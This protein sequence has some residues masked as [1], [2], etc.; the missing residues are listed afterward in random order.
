M[1]TSMSADS[2]ARIAPAAWRR[3]PTLVRAVIAG[4]AV[5]V[6]ATGPC[7]GLA[8]ANLRHALWLPWSG[9]VVALYLWAY[10]RYLQGRGWPAA[11]AEARRRGLR[12]RRLPWRVW[13]WSLAAG[14]L[15]WG[16]VLAARIAVDLWLD[17]PSSPASSLD[18]YPPLAVVQYVLTASALAGIAEEA[19]FRGYMQGPL[20]RRYGPLAAVLVVGVA[21]W[22]A[23]GGAYREDPW[24]FVGRLWFY[25]AGS[26]V[27]GTLAHLTGS[28]LPGIVLHAAAD[29]LGFGLLWLWS[30]GGGVSA[31]AAGAAGLACLGPAVLAYRRLA[32]ETA[33]GRARPPAGPDEAVGLAGA[34]TSE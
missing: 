25:L 11:A 29:V 17:L 18:G 19:G 13:R 6:A 3:L 10:W 20:E 26:A 33:A 24:L 1:T 2:L 7:S 12:A 9:P 22:L 27:F 23:H 30:T 16:C 4:S 31:A 32:V 8:L 5:T 15:G 34:P 21:F 28:I 14:G